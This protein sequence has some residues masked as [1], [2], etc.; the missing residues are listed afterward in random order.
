MERPTRFP[1]SGAERTGTRQWRCSKKS[2][3]SSRLVL[4]LQLMLRPSS[5][6]GNLQGLEA[7]VR[8][9]VEL[10]ALWGDAG[11]LAGLPRGAARNDQRCAGPA[12]GQR[13]DRAAAAARAPRQ[14]DQRSP[15][16]LINV[17]CGHFAD[18]L[19]TSREVPRSAVN[20]HSRCSIC[21]V[22]R[23]PRRSAAGSFGQ[24]RACTF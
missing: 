19:R 14:P 24:R 4:Y 5:S 11:G 21:T 3:H 13:H 6:V 20:D 16:Y 8:H 1:T 2:T 9:G 7:G 23:S 22:I 15:H 17:R 18:P 12:R 10:T